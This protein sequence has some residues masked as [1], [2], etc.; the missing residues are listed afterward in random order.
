[1]QKKILALSDSIVDFIYSPQIR[2]RFPDIDFVI[3]CGDIPLNYLEY[4]TTALN[5][6]SYYVFGNHDDRSPH[7]TDE[8]FG[9]QMEASNLH[10]RVVFDGGLLFAGIEGSVRYRKGGIQYSQS[11]M[12]KNVFHLVPA[13]LLRRLIHGRFLDVFVSHA[14]PWGIHDREDLA[15]QGIKAFRWLLKVFRPVC[16]LHGH[17]HI[18]HPETPRETKFH[19][20]LVINSYRYA[21]TVVEPALLGRA[22][23]SYLRHN[24]V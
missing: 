8:L 11:E 2:S 4:A 6:P 5:V 16:H 15:H 3:G 14:P 9:G 22:P 13:L 19:Q 17:T 12:W 24:G 1:M 10:R 7:L 21:E 20:T 23:M 18:Y